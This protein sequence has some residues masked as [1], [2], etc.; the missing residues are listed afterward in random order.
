MAESRK[1]M[2]YVYRDP[3]GRILRAV[4]TPREFRVREAMDRLASEGLAPQPG[5]DIARK[6][7]YNWTDGAGTDVFIL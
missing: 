1:K 4:E 7:V 3:E 6:L 5:Y 2:L